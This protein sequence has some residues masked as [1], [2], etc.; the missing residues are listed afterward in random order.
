MNKGNSVETLP[1]NE[2][3]KKRKK[4]RDM[5]KWFDPLVLVQSGIQAVIT[6]VFAQYADG[7]PLQALLDNVPEQTLKDRSDL[8]KELKADEEGAIWIDYVADLGDGFDSTYAVAYMLG[9]KSLHIENVD[10]ALLRGKLLIMGGD[11]VYPYASKDDYRFRMRDPYRY[12]FP[13]SQQ[14]SAEHPR[15]FLI[16]GNHDWY[17]GLKEFRRQFCAGHPVK[18]GSWVAEQYRSYFSLRLADNW[19]LWGFDS[20]VDNK[21]IDVPQQDYFKMMA[22]TLVDKANII[23]C[24]SVPIWLS[25]EDADDREVMQKG[26]NRLANIARKAMPSV[27]VHATISGDRH[28][29]NRYRAP[30][31]PTQFITAGGGGAFLHPTH[32]LK[33]NISMPWMG[34]SLELSLK[35]STDPEF[36][37]VDKEAT[38]PSRKASRDLVWENLSF[39]KTNKIFCSIIGSFYWLVAALMQATTNWNIGGC[40]LVNPFFILSTVIM[41]GI[42]RIYADPNET[43]LK[44]KLAI[45]HTSLHSLAILVLGAI[46]PLPARDVIGSNWGF[47]A[48]LL[49]MLVAGGII[50]GLIWG[51]YLIFACYRYAVHHND[52]FSALACPKYRNF[53]RLR[54][55]GDELTIYPIGLD[56][57]PERDGWQVNPDATQN[58]QTEPVII[59][60]VALNP[61]LIEGP[62]ITR[63]L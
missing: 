14:E 6:S 46:L 30:Q 36:K 25:S 41:F 21:D 23:I 62:I 31:S 2:D 5:T 40:P 15:V 26:V 4:F 34:K 54:I 57:V 8:R 61:H 39:F 13:D 45:L 7:R 55:K 12:A 56:N 52:A 35:T 63:R 17:D 53:L 37:K 9:Q 59:P 24:A 29:Y 58:D 20:G 10:K 50:G 16:P 19:W 38:Y 49:E 42:F 28:S 3:L 22:E 18:V 60:K 32:D 43:K 27:Q 51:G 33:D 11:Q 44:N 47:W 48:F 1:T